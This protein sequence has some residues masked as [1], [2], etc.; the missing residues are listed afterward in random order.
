MVSNRS[1][2]RYNHTETDGI[3]TTNTETPVYLLALGALGGKADELS[4][5]E[6]EFGR[7]QDNEA[8]PVIS[9]DGVSLDAECDLKRE[10]KRWKI[11]NLIL[12]VLYLNI[13]NIT[14]IFE[15]EAKCLLLVIYYE[16]ASEQ[17]TLR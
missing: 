6:G 8:E 12:N 10:A 11:Q 1:L 4:C 5:R 2:T 3:D 14:R 15:F 16:R 9:F 7:L 17:F 13:V